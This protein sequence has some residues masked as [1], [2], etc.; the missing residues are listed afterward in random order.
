M[1]PPRYGRCCSIST[2]R[3]TQ[4]NPRSIQRRQVEEEPYHFAAGVGTMRI[5]ERSD[6]ASARPRVTAAV[7]NPL[8]QDWL[9][10]LA[11]VHS[12]GVM[13]AARL[14]LGHIGAKVGRR[15]R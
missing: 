6:R 13:E 3:L 2:H 7:Q 11:D 15:L 10:A 14:T 5:G 12:A 9:S 1:M 8:L 4:S